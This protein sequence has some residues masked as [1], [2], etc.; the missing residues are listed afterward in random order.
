MSFS[1]LP[2]DP[3]VF[4]SAVR[5]CG[6]VIEKVSYCLNFMS[7]VLLQVRHLSSLY[8]SFCLVQ[9]VHILVID[10]KKPPY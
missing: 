10:K 5:I 2:A 6:N 8:F 9:A 7:W 1:Q 3:G 4:S